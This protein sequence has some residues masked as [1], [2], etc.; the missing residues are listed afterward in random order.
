MTKL[1]KRKSMKRVISVLAGLVLLPAIAAAQAV[2]VAPLPPLPPSPPAPIVAPVPPMPP[3]PVVPPLPPLPPNA[4]FPVWSDSWKLFEV[5]DRMWDLQS[6]LA[7]K[8]F[9]FAEVQ[10]KVAEKAAW[11]TDFALANVNVNVDVLSDFKFSP[12]Q[13]QGPNP[14]PNP[15]PVMIGR[16]R[17]DDERGMY[18][19]GLGALQNRQYN[20]AILQ[21]DRV[22]AIKGTHA[23]AATYWKAF[24]EARLVRTDDALATIAALRRDYPQSRYLPEA[25]VLEADV[26]RLA[27]Q[28]VD[29]QTLD[30]NDELKLIAINGIANTDPDR[31]IPLLEGVLNGANTLGNKR[32]ALFVL[33]LS[34]DPRAH[35]ILLRYA[36]GGGSPELQVEAIRNLVSRREGQT[37]ETELRDIYEST[38]DP[39]IRRAVIEAYGN[40]NNKNALLAIAK[41]KTDVADNKRSALNRLQNLATPAEL[42]SIYQ[43]EPDPELRI[44]IANVF[45][46]MGATEQVIQIVKTEKDLKVRQRA[47]QN[48]G[49][50]RI[51]A[52]GTLLVDLY[53]SE[54]ERDAKRSIIRAL[55][56]QNNATAL[57]AIA[58]KETNLDLKR[59]IVSAIS[60]MAGRDKVA[61]DYLMEMI[62]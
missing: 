20:R 26:R 54:Q 39:T 25:K 35:Q 19:N 55:R 24:S 58:R 43:V 44:Q 38:Q 56:V 61:A 48:L 42:W 5:Q 60:D 7:E 9:K 49:G 12:F 21:F 17:E 31:A 53:G 6:K 18:N 46:S 11:A 2:P 32:R 29:P 23:D 14:N 1:N 52:T 8:D 41:S 4:P 27:G 28:R 15:R 51:E 10:A 22:I 59:E 47:L 30:A 57:V 16:G 62:K 13:F 3:M 40:A 45:M 36:K 37:S 34:K 50:Q 33:A